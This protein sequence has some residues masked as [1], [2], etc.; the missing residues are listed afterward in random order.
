[1]MKA[2]AL[3]QLARSDFFERTRQFQY[4][5]VVAGTLW[6][7]SAFVPGKGASYAVM[8]IDKYRGVYNS[9]WL[10]LVFATVS[11]FALLLFG[12]YLVKG[13]V[14]RDRE[15]RVGE[16]LASTSM[17]KFEYVLGKMLSNVAVLGSILAILFVEAIAMQLLRGEDRSIN[18][19]QLGLPMALFGI[20][21]ICVVSAVAVLFEVLPLLRGSIGNVAY[22]FCWMGSLMVLIP[23]NKQGPMTSKP[24]DLLGIS[25]V[26][27]AIGP[28]IAKLE[29][30]AFVSDMAL[31]TDAPKHEHIY[32]FTG[33]AYSASLVE[34]RLLWI[35]A[36]FAIV[37]VAALF[38]DRFTSSSRAQA[39]REPRFFA[40][41]TAGFDRVTTPVLDVVFRSNFGAIVLAELRLMLKGMGFWWYGVAIGLWIWTLLS[42]AKMMPIALGLAWLWPI[43]IWSQMGTREA[44][45][46]TELFIFPTLQPLRRQFLAQLCAG[47]LVALMAGSGALL[48]DIFASDTHALVAVLVGSLFIPTL[49]LACGA[50]S[51]TT[52]TFEIA[53]MLLWYLGPMNGS[54]LD[55]TS[56]A[57]APGFAAATVVLACVAFAARRARLA[58]A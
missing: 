17:G 48:H 58:A 22:F 31:G 25:Y 44:I 18:L 37:G 20:P 23:D 39:A 21:V 14:Q 4:L 52:R 3:Y 12:F 40:A 46:D 54:A 16:I 2:S 15:T 7:G 49:A 8:S 30:K 38:F 24:T 43:L 27:D 10:G 53:F 51:A 19:V 45:N 42:P 9:A 50:V 36:A 5:I 55:Y 41:L 6:L 28:A 13:A 33:M 56:A 57:Y 29:H 34:S 32:T 35:L 1:M 11:T 26:F 47:I